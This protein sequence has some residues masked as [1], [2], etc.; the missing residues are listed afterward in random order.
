MNH[1]HLHTQTWSAAAIDS[2]L[3]RGSLHD[4]QTLFAAVQRQVD[5]ARL[6]L[7][8]TA[9]RQANGAT[10]LA[11]ALVRRLHPGL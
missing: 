7:R 5:V 9:Q 8:V 1:R 4:W 3:D 2:T 10:L 11:A 6:V